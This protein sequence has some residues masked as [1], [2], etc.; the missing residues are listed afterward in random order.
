MRIILVLI[1]LITVLPVSAQKISLQKQ[2]KL[3]KWDVPAA[4]YSGI[5]WLGGDRY[6]VVSDKDGYGWHEFRIQLNPATGRV[7]QADHLAFH[8]SQNGAPSRDAEGIA[9]YPERN[10]LF[11]ATESDQRVLELDSLGN[12]TGRELQLPAKVSRDSIYGN[13]GLESLTYNSHTHTFWT[14]TEHTLKAD[15]EKSTA[16]HQVPCRLRLLAFGDD[17]QLKGEYLYET[18][19]PQARKENRIYVFGVS[20]LTALDD[21][22]LFVLEREFYVA[23][24][25][26]GSWVQNKIYKVSPIAQ[27]TPLNK[28]LLCSF[29]TRLNLTRRNLA[30]YEGMCLGP[31]LADGSRALILLS[32]SQ[33]GYGNSSYH[34]KDYIR[35]LRLSGF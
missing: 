15:G 6:A 22:S 31:F 20:A 32:D 26:I 3:S 19:V 12:L 25:F 33:G 2:Q 18:D 8:D 27:E 13:Y 23:R 17:L 34:L 21:G 35:V 29:K 7:E 14:V 4:Q 5:T 1:S 24:K 9:F 10:T 30:N 11:I 16:R 28:E